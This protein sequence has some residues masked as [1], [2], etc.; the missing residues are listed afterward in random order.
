[1]YWR[2]TQYSPPNTC[3]DA[4]YC[5]CEFLCDL[6]V[7]FDNLLLVGNFN[8]P[9]I[10][11]IEISVVSLTNG[12]FN[13]LVSRF[14]LHQPTHNE[15]VLR[16]ST[17][18]HLNNKIVIS[19]P[20]SISDHSKFSFPLTSRKFPEGLHHVIRNF[21]EGNFDAIFFWPSILIWSLF[22]YFL[23]ISLYFLRDFQ[24]PYLGVFVY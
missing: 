2:L 17:P 4:T 1:M 9:V 6:L 5:F 24:N 20:L 22:F 21:W 18:H 10:N 8:F 3:S 7:I 16:F 11:W 23:R 12:I 13:D 19:E 14:A 15:N